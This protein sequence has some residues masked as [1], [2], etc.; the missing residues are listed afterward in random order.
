[1][2]AVNPSASGEVRKVLRKVAVRVGAFVLIVWIVALLIQNVYAYAA[3]GGL[4]LLA[5]GVAIWVYVYLRKGSA[6]A[7]ILQSADVSTAQGRKEAMSKLAD[8]A[9]RG[10]VA[11]LFAKANLLMHED[12]RKALEQLEQINLTKVMAP[13]AD[14]ARGQ[15]AMIHLI[16]GETDKARPLADAID[17]SR[18]D[19][20]K[21][22][23]A[24]AAVVSEAWARS[25]LGKRANETL[26][27]YDADSAELSEIRPQL[28][29]SRAF[30]AAAQNDVKRMRYALRR[31][32]AANP[33]LLAGFV[34]KKVHPLL[35]KEARQMLMQSGA[36][37]KKMIR[38]R[39]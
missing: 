29:R 26:D 31:L 15:R 8:K 34:Q 1:M 35:E 33:Q 25:G 16:L 20:I 2:P 39:M 36:V 13:I 10:D 28:F 22:R 14:E 23:A 37:P 3:A 21:S 7:N 17:L 24:L 5:L 12:P 19:Q 30:A 9:D 27:L 11:A 6:V 4:T 32:K 38:Q 18:H